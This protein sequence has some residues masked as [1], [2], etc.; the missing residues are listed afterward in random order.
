MVSF[1]K[2]LEDIFNYTDGRVVRWVRFPVRVH[3]EPPK[4]HPLYKEEYE[5]AVLEGLK[6]WAES[7]KKKILSF[8][9]NNA[10]CVHPWI[11]LSGV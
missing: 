6:I 2:I 9:K 7:I 8:H 3:I 5:A 10:F 4:D 1:V 11:S